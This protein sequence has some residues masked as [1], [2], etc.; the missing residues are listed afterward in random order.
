[1]IKNGLNEFVK[2][3][4]VIEEKNYLTEELTNLSLN[5]LKS[6]GDILQ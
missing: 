3:K 2:D 4:I 6:E 1:M 5:N